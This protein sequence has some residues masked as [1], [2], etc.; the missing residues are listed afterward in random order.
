MHCWRS[1]IFKQC[2]NVCQLLLPFAVCP[3]ISPG[4]GI[5]DI[6][7][8]REGILVIV[9]RGHV[10]SRTEIVGRDVHGAFARLTIVRGPIAGVAIKSSLALVATGTFCVVLTLLSTQANQSYVFICTF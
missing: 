6:L 3:S 9:I 8:R 4:A 2:T 7:F 5:A 10:A 1:I